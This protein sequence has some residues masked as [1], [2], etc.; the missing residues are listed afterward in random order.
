VVI[1]TGLVLY[2]LCL[3]PMVLFACIR[4][5]CHTDRIGAEP[6]ELDRQCGLFRYIKVIKPIVLYL[7]VNIYSV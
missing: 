4:R 6:T 3:G 7:A 5:G 1:C 2:C